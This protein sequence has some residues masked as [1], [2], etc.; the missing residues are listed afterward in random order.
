MFRASY[1]SWT[2]KTWRVNTNVFS[3]VP[4]SAWDWKQ[5]Q[6]LNLTPAPWPIAGDLLSSTR[7][8]QVKEIGKDCKFMQIPLYIHRKA[9]T[10]CRDVGAGFYRKVCWHSLILFARLALYIYI[11]QIYQKRLLWCCHLG[12]MSSALQD[13]I[14]FKNGFDDVPESLSWQPEISRYH[15]CWR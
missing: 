1:A 6:T 13:D 2:N 14:G 7:T 8:A 3:W 12:S 10:L 15:G 11:N 4:R 9:F 5:L